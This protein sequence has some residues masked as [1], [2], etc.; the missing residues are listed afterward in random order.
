MDTTKKVFI[1]QANKI[2]ILVVRERNPKDDSTGWGALEFV[3]NDGT[4]FVVSPEQFGQGSGESGLWVD[5]NAY[6]DGYFAKLKQRLQKRFPNRSSILD[7]SHC[8]RESIC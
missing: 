8:N 3:L 6:S 2:G 5:M 1:K 7:A 4:I